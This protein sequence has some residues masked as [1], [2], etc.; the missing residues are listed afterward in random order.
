MHGHPGPLSITGHCQH[1]RYE[2]TWG[3]RCG[4]VLCSIR[5]IK[6]CVARSHSLSQQL[7]L[8]RN[9]AGVRIESYLSAELPCSAFRSVR[10]VRCALPVRRRSRSSRSSRSDHS[11]LIRATHSR[12]GRSGLPAVQIIP[13]GQSD[14]SGIPLASSCP[15]SC[16][17]ETHLRLLIGTG[18]DLHGSRSRI[19]TIRGVL[20]HPCDSCPP[21]RVHDDSPPPPPPPQPLP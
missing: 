7:A 11:T 14:P 5:W 18:N 17:G 8:P 1:N 3:G 19:T 12:L 10:S 20:W 15:L 13:A 16:H 9:L 4:S 6:V 2:A 21:C